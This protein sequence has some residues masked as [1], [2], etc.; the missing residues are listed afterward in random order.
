MSAVGQLLG[1]S[2]LS[3]FLQ[4]AFERFASPELLDFLLRW[5]IDL[6]E[7]ESLKRTS[8]MIQALSDEAEVKQ[9]TNVAVKLWLDHLKQLL[10]DA[11]DI[12]DEYATELLRLKLESANQTQQVRN[13]SVPLTPS[14]QT[15]SVSSWLNSGMESAIKSINQTLEGI[16]S[17]GPKVCNIAE[18]LRGIKRF[19]SE[20]K[21][22]NQRLKS[23]AQEGVALGLNSSMGFGYSRP[24]VFS[25]RP[26][27][28][29]LVNK[30]KVFGRE[31]DMEK[32]VGWLLSDKTPCPSDN[33]NNFSVLPIVGMG[34]VGKTTLAQLVYND[35]RV[36]KH[37]HLKAWVCVSED[38]D[39][40]RLTKEILESATGA[41]PLSNSLDML[42]LKLQEALSEKRFLLVLDDVWNEN[43]ERWDT[44]S[45]T[46]A[47]GSPG[48]K[49]L[50]TT[51]NKGVASIVRTAPNDHCLKGLSEEAC[52]SL[53]R[54]HAFM[55]ENT[56]AANQKLEVFGHEIVKKCKGLPLAVK[57]LA[58]LL[59]DKR[60]NNQW[61][62]ILENEIWDL[63]ENEILPSLMLSY[64]HLP[65]LLKRCFAYC[66]L[67]PKDYVFSKIEIVV[68]WMAEG[69]VQ[70]EGIK[71]L[72]DIAGEYFDE[73]I[74]RSF[75]EL[76]N[77]FHPLVVSRL[78]INISKEFHRRSFFESS[79]NIRSGFV[80][81]DLIHDLAQ[82]VSGGI[83][84]KKEYDRQSQVLTTTRHLSYVM[85]N[86]NVEATGFGAVKTLRTLLTLNDV[87]GSPIYF[88]PT[89]QFKFQFLR[90]L[91]FRNCCNCELPDS[92]GKLKHLRLLDLSF[93]DIVKLPDSIGSLYN[94]QSLVLSGCGRL[95]QLP[96]DMGNL[97]NL[98][99]L[100]FP[101]HW[102][103]RKIPLGVGNLTNLE[104]L[105]TLDAGPKQKLSQ[106]RG[107]LDNSNL[108]NL[109]NNGAEAMVAR[110]HLLGLQL[111]KLTSLRYLQISICENLE[112]LSK[113]LYTLTSLRR[114][115]I[116]SCPDLVS[117]RETRLPTSLQELKIFD[118][119]N[120]RSLPKEL[121]T[122]M[123]LK[124]FAIDSC[125]ALVSFQETRLPTM[126][127]ELEIIDCENL[128][129]LPMGL[130]HN[131]TSFQ[132]LE[133]KECPALESIP[134]MELS[135]AL[136]EV[137]I[138]NC[139]QLNCFPKGLNKLTNLKQ[140]EIVDCFFLM[141]CKNLEPLH[142]FGLHNLIYLSYLTIGGCRALLSIPNG[143]LPTNLQ[144][145]C[146]KDCP[147]LESL[148]DGLSDLTSLKCL[149]IHNCPKLTP[150]YQKKEGEEWSKIA[151]IP[152]VII[153]GIWQ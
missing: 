93:S 27:S 132:R 95:K 46:F 53:I 81:H 121:H 149:E 38:F 39:V 67:F 134:D 87:A 98:R 105:G 131:L 115:V 61:K 145:F 120:L 108:E 29:S 47:F 18:E 78:F 62:A 153:D 147:I 17:I 142:T 19:R 65:P 59:R 76:S 136:C 89:M 51:R 11:E 97:V 130:L 68:L 119:E 135:T 82:F 40:V 23:V 41:S 15:S 86:Y 2:F 22:I 150:R 112:L 37:F 94:L 151:Q 102:C 64:Y 21:E 45:T 91:R 103:F 138:L 36:K 32:I 129:S 124:E 146:I 31:E 58:G 128:K 122:L 88:F 83:Y 72:E 141:E 49:I 16:Q 101:R 70:P 79:S 113:A 30:Y 56:S 110:Q 8:A 25:Q 77:C 116:E 14:S 100:I 80:M 20:V 34:G 144:D 50:I 152:K 133:I 24:V 75:F 139:A 28:S 7:V 66:A 57:T 73:L 117:F 123:S 55:D 104:S 140:L 148:Y 52:F 35:E 74:M 107:T 5:E 96:E 109:G 33:N 69:I 6:D 84:C 48:S 143:L 13:P 42:H 127:E 118:C 9:F 12:L 114:L 10:Y 63:R 43:Y 90:V 92:V 126:L 71:R 137:S 26:P 85:D 44:L 99:I 1:G 4:V 3:A 60:E 111:H 125:P 106:L 54:R